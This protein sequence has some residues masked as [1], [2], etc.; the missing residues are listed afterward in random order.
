MMVGGE[1]AP[2]NWRPSADAVAGNGGDISITSVPLSVC[3]H[4]PCKA[5]E[6][7]EQVF[8]PSQ[9]LSNASTGR[10]SPQYP[11]RA[12]LLEHS[13]CQIYCILGFYWLEKANFMPLSGGIG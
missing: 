6:H 11:C 8:S 5:R 9:W 2:L 10:L 1:G 7:N 4:Q 13:S 3:P 12:Y